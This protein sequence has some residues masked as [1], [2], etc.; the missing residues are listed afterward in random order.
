MH[1]PLTYWLRLLWGIA[2]QLEFDSECAYIAGST[3]HLPANRRWQH[4]TAAASHAAAHFV[5]SPKR[6]DG[7]DLGPIARVLMALLED[8]RVEAL[9][10]RELPG[11]ARLWRPLHYAT[12]DTGVGFECLA[13]RLARSLCDPAYDDPDPWVRK[14]R[15]LCFFDLELGVCAMRTPADL[16]EAATRLGHDIGQMRLPFNAKAG[17]HLPDYRDDHR[18]MWAAEVLAIA[19]P[20]SLGS[21]EPDP[22]SPDQAKVDESNVTHH[23]E[24]DRLISRL[25]PAWCRVVEA[26][27]PVAPASAIADTTHAASRQLPGPVRNLASRARIVQANIGDAFDLDALVHWQVGHRL[28]RPAPALVYRTR[29][30]VS[31]RTSLWMLIDRSASTAD[32]EPSSD[33]GALKVAAQSALA[34]GLALQARGIAFGIAAFNSDGRH[35]VRWQTVKKF[36]E[37]VDEAMVGRL[38]ALRPEGSTRLGAVLRHA[39]QR[40]AEQHATQRWVVLLS[41]GQSHDI[42]VHDPSYLVEDARHAVRSASRRGVRI[43]CLVFKPDGNRDAERIFGRGSALLVH[44]LSGLPG[45]LLRLLD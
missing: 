18:W 3:I 29:R 30:A 39:T 13:A 44:G 20:P 27:A 4:H 26:A 38:Q 32:T 31:T 10:M 43:G 9:A 8:A 22:D 7:T 16:R 25:R 21:A 11:L 12:P 19:P 28:R 36:A 24:W 23:P 35:R 42:D 2:P 5:Y 6:F 17:L 41:D 33:G 45:A 37:P 15:D 40:L 1:A 34:L 14:G